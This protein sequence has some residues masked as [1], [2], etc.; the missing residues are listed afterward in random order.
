MKKRREK[1]KKKLFEIIRK[2]KGKRIFLFHYTPKGFF[3]II[4]DKE[5]PHHGESA[6]INFF[7]QAIKR[8]KP[9]LVICGHMEEYQGK[10]KLGQTLIVATGA[11]SEGKAAVI[12]FDEEKGK[13][14]KVRFLN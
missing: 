12:E 4:K 3:D 11:A 10:K 8:Y 2:T 6:G 14:R 7:L 9:K 13:V 1:T 5:N